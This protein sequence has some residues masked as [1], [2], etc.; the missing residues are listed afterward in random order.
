MG[1]S[2]NLVTVFRATQNQLGLRPSNKAKLLS[3]RISRKINQDKEILSTQN[4]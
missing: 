2:Y 4:Q 3:S 1:T